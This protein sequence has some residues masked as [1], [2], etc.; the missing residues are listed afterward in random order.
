MSGF[1]KNFQ[2][3]PDPEMA[4]VRRL[5]RTTKPLFRD[6][7]VAVAPPYPDY[8]KL[9]VSKRQDPESGPACPS[10]RDAS[11][12][13]EVVLYAYSG[14]GFN[15]GYQE[16]A[17][18]FLLANAT[19]IEIALRRKLYAW[20]IKQ[21]A[22]HREEDLPHVPEL[23]TY[24]KK[25]EKQVPLGDPSAIEQLFKLV[26]VGLADSGLDECG[27]IAFEFQTGWDRDHGLGVLMH[28]DRVLA[29]GGMGELIYG[30]DLAAGARTVQSYDMDD[31]D[32]SLQN[33]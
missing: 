4:D 18:E 13:M 12:D 30:T 25:I 8:P 17:W 3:D 10:A 24:W 19:G 22:Q 5:W 31:A 16:R 23:Q 2:P 32:F 14:N 33:S 21:M 7:V 29:A 9:K 11:S 20:H 6:T 26:G 28:R 27:F 15:S 1:L